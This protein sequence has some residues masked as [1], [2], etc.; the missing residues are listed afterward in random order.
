MPEKR[1]PPE[2]YVGLELFNRGFYFECHDVWEEI[3]GEAK[4]KN[5]IFY[6]ALIMSAVSLYH[7]GNENLEGALSCLQKATRQFSQL[8]EIFLSLDVASFVKQM[9]QFFEGM[10]VG[11][12]KITEELLAK[13]RPR[14]VLEES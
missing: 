14:I 2:F 13:P 1:H 3:W 4:G 5:K 12:T 10:A 6:Q 8:P 7:F 9:R 11:Q